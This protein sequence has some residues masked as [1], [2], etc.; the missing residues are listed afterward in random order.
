MRRQL[1]LEQRIYVCRCYYKYESAR[2][3]REEFIRYFPGQ[4]PPSRSTIHD[5]VTKFG[6]TEKLDEIGENLERS[7]QKS[8]PKLA[9]QVG[10]SVSSA[11]TATKLLK[12]KPYKCT[13]VH[14][15]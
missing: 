9:Q 5:L 12:L 8:L 4:L 7:P 15:V 1:T 10:I 13:R 11:H 2:R 3:I 6:T 14:C